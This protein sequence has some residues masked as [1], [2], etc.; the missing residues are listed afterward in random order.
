MGN[1]LFRFEKFNSN[2]NFAYLMTSLLFSLLNESQIEPAKKKLYCSI[3]YVKMYM[4]ISN[5]N[6]H[7]V[8]VIAYVL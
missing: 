5:L 2:N 6:D 4:H 1:E 7:T 3:I 8:T